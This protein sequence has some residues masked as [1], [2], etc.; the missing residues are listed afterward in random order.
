MRLPSFDC[1]RITLTLLILSLFAGLGYAQEGEKTDSKKSKQADATVDQPQI[2]RF[3]RI[4]RNAKKEP[5][6][7]ETSVT[8][9]VTKNADGK[10]VTVDLIG[11]VHIGEEKYYEDLNELF[12]QYDAL[13]YELVAPEGTVVPKGG[14]ERGF[15]AI[16][17]IQQGMQSVLGLEFQ[18]E[19][20]DYTVPNFVHADMTPEEFSASMEQNEESI[21]KMALKAMG[22]GMARQSKAQANGSASSETDLLMAM[23]GNDKGKIR[24]VMAEQ[25]LDLESGM[26]IFQGKDGSTI[27]DHRNTKAFDVLRKQIDSGKTRIGVFY[28]AGHLPDMDQRLLKS[29]GMKRGGQVWLE[30]WDLDEK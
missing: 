1:I 3:M 6:G 16:S 11:V 7:M 15:N 25:M 5:V 21:F 17:G 22:Q 12:T 9:Y 27:I 13:L 23:L 28:G 26:V 20:I 10:K 18:L 30:A 19:H 24:E 14:G 29:F 4:R 8:R 2:N